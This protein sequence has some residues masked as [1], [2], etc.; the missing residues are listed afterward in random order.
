MMRSWENR[1]DTFV[2]DEP[3]YAHYLK[4]TGLNHPVRD[5][6]LEHHESDWEKVVQELTAPC[7]KPVYY[8]KHM[9]HHLLPN[10]SRDW[11]SKVTNI[12]LIRHP[13]EMMTSLV[14]TIP[15]PGIEE[16]GLPQQLE[17][18]DSLRIAGSVPIVLESK[19]VLHNTREMLTTLCNQL[20]VPFYEE[21]LRWPAGTRKTDGIWAPHWYGSVEASTSFTPWKS[22]EERVPPELESM[23]LECEDIYKQLAAYKMAPEGREHAP[24]I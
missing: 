17:L 11:L 7:D 18:F 6:V 15:N 20:G 13:R 8:Q 21:M 2:C 14:K 9:S 24:N 4:V 1:P 19:D 22:K 3:F 5:D 16:T 23:C 12:F 10:I